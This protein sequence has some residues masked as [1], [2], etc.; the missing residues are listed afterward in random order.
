MPLRQADAQL[1][2]IAAHEGNEQPAEMQEADAV[3]ISGHCTQRTG[4]REI[5][6]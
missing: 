5:A 1:C 4:Q 6:A 2:R 3:D